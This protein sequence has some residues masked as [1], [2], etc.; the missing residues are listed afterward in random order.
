[1]TKLTGCDTVELSKKRMKK[2]IIQFVLLIAVIGIATFLFKQKPDIT[3]LPFLPEQPVFKE[4]QINQVKLKVEVADTQKKRSKGLGGRE[5]LA[6]GEG[7]LF[8]L[9]KPDKYPFWM[10]GLSFPLDFVWISGEKI[11]DLLQNIQPPTPG[12]TD[13]SL[14]IYQSKEDVDKVLEVAAGTVQRMNIKVGDTIKLE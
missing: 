7:M 1:M 8:I 9:P 12:Q 6:S 13:E 10:K 2:F 11:V 5:S 3:N 4:L 14:P